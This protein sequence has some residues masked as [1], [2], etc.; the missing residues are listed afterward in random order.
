MNKF[1]TAIAFAVSA[2]FTSTGCAQEIINGE[3]HVPE[4]RIEGFIYDGADRA[5]VLETISKITTR[6]GNDPGSWVYEWTKVADAELGRAE[7]A[8]ESD[9]NAQAET[10]FFSAANYYAIAG[11]PEYHSDAER[12]ALLKHFRAYERGGAYMAAPMQVISVEA[13]GR[14]F[15]TYFH[16]PAGIDHPPL[17]LWT[18]GTDKFK[19]HAYKTVKRLLDRGFAVVTFDLA[20]TGESTFWDLL[21]DGEFVH[22]AVLDAYASRDDVDASNIFEVGVSFGGHYAAKMAARNDPRLRAVA[23]LCGPIHSPFMQTTEEIAYILGTEEGAT[24][25]AFAHRI[26]ADPSNPDQ[27]ASSIRQFSLVEQ[28]LIGQGQT[29]KTPL[30]VMNGG[31]DPLSP[32]KDLQLLANSAETSE[33]WVMGMAGHCARDYFEPAVTDVA[34]WLWQY[35]SE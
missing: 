11:F 30:L 35:A 10:L 19:G 18:H 33:L 29:I 25:R 3:L 6:D 14:S 26:G 7:Q 12:D 1:I 34:E 22:Q 2:V 16:R 32:I 31:R 17:I 5:I 21:S 23:S 28:G 9:Q 4:R 27:V 8:A 13:R 15:N 20:G 24:V